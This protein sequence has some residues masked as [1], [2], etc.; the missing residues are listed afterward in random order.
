MIASLKVECDGTV[1]DLLEVNSQDFLGHIIVIQFVV[2]EGHIDIE[3][4]VLPVRE[5]LKLKYISQIDGLIPDTTIKLF[6]NIF[7]SY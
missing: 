6:P 4:Q 7:L 3:G 5:R 1:R 2:A